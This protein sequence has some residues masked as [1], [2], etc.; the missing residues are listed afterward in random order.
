MRKTLDS[1]VIRRVSGL[2]VIVSST[3]RR[4]PI[5][6]DP[7][8]SLAE[9]TN[10]GFEIDERGQIKNLRILDLGRSGNSAKFWHAPLL[11]FGLGRLMDGRISSGFLMMVCSITFIGLAITIPVAIN[12]ALERR[13][14]KARIIQ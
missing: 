8:T 13:S 5:D 4:I 11:P 10:V 14:S 2:L 3:G 9:G 7:S 12:D 1:G 6:I